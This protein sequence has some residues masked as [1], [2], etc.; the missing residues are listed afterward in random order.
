M[1]KCDYC[2][3]VSRYSCGVVLSDS[4]FVDIQSCDTHV[5]I[6]LLRQNHLLFVEGLSQRIKLFSGNEGRLYPLSSSV[7]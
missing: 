3:K 5:G 6:A 4:S 7:A 1:K 2:K